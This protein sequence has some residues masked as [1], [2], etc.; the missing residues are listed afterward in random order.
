MDPQDSFEAGG[1]PEW[2]PK[3]STGYR[4]TRRWSRRVGSNGSVWLARLLDPGPDPV[5]EQDDV[6][7]QH[8]RLE[9]HERDPVRLLSP[10]DVPDPAAILS[11]GA[12]GRHV[13]AVDAPVGAFTRSGCSVDFVGRDEAAVVEGVRQ[14]LL[15]R[16]GERGVHPSSDQVG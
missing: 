6:R 3:G 12:D 4:P 11:A 9:V 13:L 7:W 14:D 15:V 5:V 1:A 16:L 8:V 2:R 10:H